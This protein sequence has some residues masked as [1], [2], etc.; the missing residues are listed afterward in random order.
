MVELWRTQFL[1]DFEINKKGWKNAI[2]PF[3]RMIKNS[4]F[5]VSFFKEF[6]F[7][8]RI[9]F[10][11]EEK[12]T[13]AWFLYLEFRLKGKKIFF[14]IFCLIFVFRISFKTEEKMTFA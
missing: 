13:F 7:V 4:L 10:K 11:R 1:L 3:L 6:I 8:F 2:T 9:S 5:H 12:M 14:L